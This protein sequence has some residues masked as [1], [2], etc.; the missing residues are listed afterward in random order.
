MTVQETVFVMMRAYPTLYPSRVIALARLFDSY[1]SQWVNGELI[2][3]EHRLGE[4]FL[5]YKPEEL[6]ETGDVEKDCYLVA[7]R[8]QNSKAQFVYDNAYLMSKDLYSRFGKHSTVRFNGRHFDDMPEDVA[9]EWLEAAKELARAVCVHKHYPDT[10]YAP[11][12][13]RNNEAEQQASVARCTQF[14]ERFKVIT[15]CP[16]DRAARLRTLTREALALGYIL[17]PVVGA[18]EAEKAPSD[19]QT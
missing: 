14:L 6:V 16:F 13:V 10:T 4:D 7:H 11:E 2:D 19:A 9:P 18:S 1:D 5:P 3:N 12:Y 8:R 17:V 15:V